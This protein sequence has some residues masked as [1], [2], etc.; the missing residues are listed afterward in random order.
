MHIYLWNES[1]RLTEMK[2]NYISNLK[3]STNLEI[4]IQLILQYHP[5]SKRTTSIRINRC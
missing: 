3:A 2:D 1:A 5:S 4:N